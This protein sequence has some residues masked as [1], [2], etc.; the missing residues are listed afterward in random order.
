M[1]VIMLSEAAKP[2]V[3][4]W[5]VPTRT[6]PR[7][8]PTSAAEKNRP[9]AA[10][11]FNQRNTPELN[12][13][14]TTI[15]ADLAKDK[16]TGFTYYIVRLRVA[17]GELGKLDGKTLVPGMPTEVF[18]QTETRTALSYLVK[19]LSDHLKRVFREE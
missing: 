6:G 18:I 12:A 7:T 11:A 17:Q 1:T 2:F 5:M 14:V 15:S 16:A 19:P 10:P 4:S 8:P 13:I 9:P 3:R